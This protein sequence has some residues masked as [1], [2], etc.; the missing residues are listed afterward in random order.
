M[1]AERLKQETECRSLCGAIAQ[2]RNLVNT[3]ILEEWYKHFEL[4]PLLQTPRHRI[5]ILEQD[6]LVYLRFEASE[7]LAELNYAGVDSTD[8]PFRA[9]PISAVLMSAA[10]AQLGPDV[11]CGAIGPFESFRIF[12]HDDRLLNGKSSFPVVSPIKLH[13][14][15]NDLR[16]L[17]ER[18]T[19]LSILELDRHD[20]IIVDGPP[21]FQHIPD[22]DLLFREAYARRVPI[23]FIVKNLSEDPR[24]SIFG[25]NF[26]PVYSDYMFAYRLLRR[27]FRYRRSCVLESLFEKG[28]HGQTYFASDIEEPLRRVSSFVCLGEYYVRLDTQR[29]VFDQFGADFVDWV[30][31]DHSRRNGGPKDIFPIIRDAE[32]AARIDHAKK[33]EVEIAMR[34]L[35]ASLG[36]HLGAHMNS[37]RFGGY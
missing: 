14:A 21:R 11:H 5:R 27:G 36:I 7:Q 9:F 35:Y 24:T 16:Y 8:Y 29:W 17:L 2:I 15:V 25:P 28:Y 33:Q 6:P 22:G 26:H 13:H 4:S 3:E 1:Y 23:V 31:A 10:Y 32:K 19:A 20:L 34:Q 12:F 18:E 37:R 30:L